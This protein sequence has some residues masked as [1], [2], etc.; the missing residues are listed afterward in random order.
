MDKKKA[1]ATPG[2]TINF[3]TNH[4]E[5]SLSKIGAKVAD[6][7]DLSEEIIELE[8]EKKQTLEEV[9]TEISDLYETLDEEAATP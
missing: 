2:S 3:Q 7:Q 9:Q 8:E 5:Q 4:I 6:A 1:K